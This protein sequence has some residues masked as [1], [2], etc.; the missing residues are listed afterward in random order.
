MKLT[1]DRAAYGIAADDEEE[2]TEKEGAK[3]PPLS[4]GEILKL[5][6]VTPEKKETQPPPRFNEASLVKFLEENDIGR[7]STYAEILRKIEDR[8]YVRKKDRRFV[9]TALGRTVIEM[10]IPFFADFFETG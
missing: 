7:P 10:L 4:E 9:P 8:E 6:S 3:L 2:A 5:V 1:G